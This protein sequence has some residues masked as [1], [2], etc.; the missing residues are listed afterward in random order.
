MMPPART[1]LL[2][3]IAALVSA[4]GSSGT[5]AD[6]DENGGAEAGDEQDLTEAPYLE[7]VKTNDAQGQKVV[8]HGFPAITRLTNPAGSLVEIAF[9]NEL[10]SSAPGYVGYEFEERDGM[11]SFT[12]GTTP[13][14]AIDARTSPPTVNVLA[15]RV[16]QLNDRIKETHWTH[17]VEHAGKGNTVDTGFGWT[18]TYDPNASKYAKLYVNRYGQNVQTKGASYVATSAY[19]PPGCTYTPELASAAISTRYKA[20]LFTIHY[21][22]SDAKCTVVDRRFTEELP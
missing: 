19:G 5:D 21:A 10:P 15:E 11:G 12:G 7:V 9:L 16:P 4:C 3:M 18:V 13:L 8:A 14:I 1:T 20:V 6:T 22:T 2:L 17:L